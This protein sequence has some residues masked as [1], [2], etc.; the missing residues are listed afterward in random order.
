[1]GDQ[2]RR[3]PGRRSQCARQRQNQNAREFETGTG[4]GQKLRHG[5]VWFAATVRCTVR[6]WRAATSGF[7]GRALTWIDTAP[8]ALFCRGG[9]QWPMHEVDQVLGF[10]P[11]HSRELTHQDHQQGQQDRRGGPAAEE[12]A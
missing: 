7:G 5:Q 2:T 8:P 1:M 10:L 12:P 11:D 6:A 4:P 9:F 3:R